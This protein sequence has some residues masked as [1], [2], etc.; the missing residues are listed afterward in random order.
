MATK[1]CTGCKADKE[2]NFFR[3]DKSR[4]DGLQFRCKDCQISQSG[5]PAR[6]ASREKYY[7]SVSQDESFK[8]N[9]TESSRRWYYENKAPSSSGPR[10]PMTKEERKIKKAEKA[11]IYLSDPV[12]HVKSLER[13]CRYRSLPESK[14]RRR[15]NDKKRKA[16]DPQYKLTC[17]LRSRVN[18]A[19]KSE[20]RNGSAVQDLGCSVPELKAHLESRFQ[21][22]MSWDNWGKGVGFWNID[23]IMPLTAFDLTDRQHFLLASCYLNLQPLWYEDNMSKRAKIS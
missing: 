19:I 2:L 6:K 18:R 14:A 9:N 10:V 21:S 11:K 7:S 4:K 16:E 17:N 8:K 20:Y 12:N 3:V 1:K 23:H 22:G 13:S 5:T 15:E